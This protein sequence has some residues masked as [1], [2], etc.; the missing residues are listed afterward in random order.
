MRVCK[1][2]CEIRLLQ[3]YSQHLAHARC[4]PTSVRNK[5]DANVKTFDPGYICLW[6]CKMPLLIEIT[7]DCEICSMIHFLSDKGIKAAENH[8]KISQ[9]YGENIMSEEV[10]WRWV[11]AFKDGCTN[12]HNV[13]WRGGGP[14]VITEDLEQRVDEKVS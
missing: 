11:K 12:I 9:V 3:C 13:E 1:C 4:V 7:A 10:V 14:S 6:P 8:Y 5:P 2:L